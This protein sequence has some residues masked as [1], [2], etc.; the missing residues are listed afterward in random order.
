MTTGCEGIEIPFEDFLGT[1]GR[2]DSLDLFEARHNLQLAVPHLL[3]AAA[4]SNNATASSI[5]NTAAQ[6]GPI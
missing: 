6:P 1:L 2:W 3:P 4:T 5:T